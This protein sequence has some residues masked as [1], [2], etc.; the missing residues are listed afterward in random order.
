[1]PS[2]P[3][4]IA[5][6]RR[7]AARSTGPKTTEGKARSRQNSLKHGLTGA[8][9]V[10]PDEDV[11]AIEERFEAF[12]A[13][14]RPKNDVARVL[15]RQAALMSIRLERS[16]R[17]EAAIL[18][19]AMLEA[20]GIE[21][22]ERAEELKRLIALIR[23]EP[24]E[25]TRKLRRIPE[26]IDWMIGRWEWLRAELDGSRWAVGDGERASELLGVKAQSDGS[27][28]LMAISQASLGMFQLLGPGDFP[29]LSD[30]QRREA[31]KGE[32]GRR[33]DGEIAR[34]HGVRE[35]LDHAAIARDRAGARREPCSTPRTRRFSR[36]ST[37]PRPSAAS[38]ARSSRS[39]GSTLSRMKSK[40]S[41]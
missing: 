31:A 23:T 24:A 26:G 9:I 17:H 28:R 35:G 8:G 33:I 34:L 25:A 10:V 37:R 13:D 2:S 36:G 6:N 30:P 27:S 21:A 41:P 4:K 5:A 32:L 1:M 20:E 7:N 40:R 11:A 29:G 16:A 12:E 22:D 38:S 19:Q 18:T 39:N 14:L 3:E 15:V